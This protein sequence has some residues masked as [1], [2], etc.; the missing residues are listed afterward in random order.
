M[1][2]NKMKKTIKTNWKQNENKS[3]MNTIKKWKKIKTKN[4]ERK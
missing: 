3:K 1:K 2:M 4:H